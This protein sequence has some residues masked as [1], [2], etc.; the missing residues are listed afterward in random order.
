MSNDSIDMLDRI[1][2]DPNSVQIAE[3]MK[4]R[5]INAGNTTVKFNILTY[6]N[7]GAE[8]QIFTP[9][10][11]GRSS[12]TPLNKYNEQQLTALVRDLHKWFSRHG[13]LYGGLSLVRDKDVVDKEV[14]I[15]ADKSKADEKNVQEVHTSPNTF[16]NVDNAKVKD[17]AEIKASAVTIKDENA[18]ERAKESQEAGMRELRDANLA[19]DTTVDTT[20]PIK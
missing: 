12:V 6:S 1:K 2:Y 8:A 3:L 5:I 4:Y 18:L 9:L 17:K 11:L 13:K 10:V 16:I 7:G 14:I 20:K 15:K 19:V